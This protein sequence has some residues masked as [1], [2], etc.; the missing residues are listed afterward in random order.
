MNRLEKL[1]Q[2]RLVPPGKKI[3][4]QDYDPGDI[5]GLVK[6]KRKENC[7]FL[8][9]SKEEQKKRF[10]EGI[11]QTEKNWKFPLSDSKERACSDAY[12]K[13]YEDVFNHTSTEWAPWYVIP[14]DH[15]WLTRLAVAAVIV[16]KMQEINPEYPTLTQ[17]Q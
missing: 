4:L 9:I 16:G 1:I 2:P 14:A 7:A 8:N 5:A 6:K 15:K 12:M 10:L 13:A 17:E 3:S 11:D